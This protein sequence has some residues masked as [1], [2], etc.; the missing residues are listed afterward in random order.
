M[1]SMTLTC[2][3][4]CAGL[5]ACANRA[6]DLNLAPLKQE[7]AAGDCRP[8]IDDI[9]DHIHDELATASLPPNQY[10]TIALSLEVED[11]LNLT[12]LVS[13]T[14]PLSPGATLVTSLGG[15]FG[16]ARKR[17]FTATYTIDTAQLT[18]KKEA[19]ESASAAAQCAFPL[20]LRG[21]LGIA[22][23]VGYNQQF[24]EPSAGMIP[25]PKEGKYGPSFGTQIQFVITKSVGGFGPVWT[26]KH[27]K[28]GGG[29]N[30]LANGK[31]KDTHG[32]I[33]TF[34]PYKPAD[35]TL[36]LGA[37]EA[38][39]TLSIATEKAKAARTAANAAGENLGRLRSQFGT[40][41]S[42]T[43]TAAEHERDQ[44]EKTAAAAE[45]EALAAATQA[46]A[47]DTAAELSEA[48]AETSKTSAAQATRDQL[49]QMLLQ[50]LA[51]R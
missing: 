33:L 26:F 22:E 17:T 4:I 25:Y 36:R 12:P 3:M 1:K 27:W 39:K 50:N 11:N 20:D 13:Y 46:R 16:R 21:D 51:P 40:L 19:E 44:A 18:P 28:Y 49:N 41:K 8:T 30:S 9:R 23:T 24:L 32:V 10:V 34:A 5:A 2:A 15:E 7:R 29:A 31:K 38:K 47:A 14:Q 43:L 48:A 42:T 6:P 37:I 35:P 45:K